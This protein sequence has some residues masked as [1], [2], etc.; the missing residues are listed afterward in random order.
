MKGM[1]GHDSEI[2]LNWQV[3]LTIIRESQ[4]LLHACI[5]SP[6]EG[7]PGALGMLRCVLEPRGH[8]SSC[9]VGVATTASLLTT[10]LL[11]VHSDGLR[12]ILVGS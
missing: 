5:G 3:Q 4:L 1:G 10:H 7:T 9:C 6:E 12:L 8:G 11:C 2:L